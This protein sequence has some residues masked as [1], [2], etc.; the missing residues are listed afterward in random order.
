MSRTMR[1]SVHTALALGLALAMASCG[2]GDEA[3]LPA[4]LSEPNSIAAS[5]VD[6]TLTP[7]QGQVVSQ[8]IDATVEGL[9]YTSTSGAGSTYQGKTNSIGQFITYPGGTTAFQVGSVN[10]GNWYEPTSTGAGGGSIVRLPS[11]SYGQTACA[12]LDANST[13][14]ILM[15][16]NASGSLY[17]LLIPSTASLTGCPASTNFFT[18]NG[19]ATTT[20]QAATHLSQTESRVDIQKKIAS[21]LF[22]IPLADIDKASVG[23][24]YSYNDYGAN[25]DGESTCAGYAN[26]HAGVDF[27]TKDVASTSTADRDVYFL[28]DGKVLKTDSANG[29]VIVSAAIS[30]NGVTED[31]K[32]GYLHL[33]SISVQ[34]GT[35]YKKG[36]KLGVQGNL[37][38]GLKASDT[39][40]Q[41]HVHVE[42][43]N[44]TAPTGAACGANPKDKVGTLD[45]LLYF[46]SIVGGST[47]K[48]KA[49][50]TNFGVLQSVEFESDLPAGPFSATGRETFVSGSC[51]LTSELKV[52]GTRT[53]NSA[54]IRT[55][56][57][58]AINRC[59]D[60]THSAQAGFVRN[61]SVQVQAASLTISSVDQC[62]FT[63]SGVGGGCFKFST[64][65]KQ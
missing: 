62:D 9:S 15:G 30:V 50:M 1:H 46:T 38:L 7:S 35:T 28:T 21:L 33:R 29:R 44:S 27:Q 64:F 49:Q 26:G 48:W 12:S 3:E 31:V 23:A 61:Y 18:Q 34:E 19:I 53:G 13:A 14:R 52:T 54:S 59:P 25:A 58:T 20:A 40:T 17:K 6:S 2:G 24:N 11:L 4:A 56:T 5:P 47:S 43:R 41:E 36:E 10:V 51:T 22:N 42:I 55:E 37:G 39:T 45:P 16:L 63:W 57:T 32:I 65:T 60:G 8:L